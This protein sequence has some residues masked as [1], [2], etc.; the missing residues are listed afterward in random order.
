IA[1]AATVA[2]AVLTVMYFP[3][4]FD[5]TLKAVFGIISAVSNAASSVLNAVGL[6]TAA[7][8]FGI[9]SAAASFGTSLVGVKAELAKKAAKQVANVAKAAWKAVAAGATL[10]SRTLNAFGHKVAAQIFGL[11]NTVVGFIGDG[12]QDIKAGS[13]VTGFKWAP[14][15][16]ATYK[17]IRSTTEQVANLAG[18]KTFAGYLNVTGIVDDVY[19]FS[20]GVK[21]FGKSAPGERTW[22]GNKSTMTA[23]EKVHWGWHNAANTL[24][25]RAGNINSIIGRVEKGVALGRM[26]NG[27]AVAR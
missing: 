6:N 8:I 20:V 11:G 12:F 5:T 25:A 10:A 4:L 27:M 15:N 9:I 16:W 7:G 13:T 1:V 2:V 23:D 18:A 3:V 19:D 24:R 17:F 26:E 14:T 22:N 21:D